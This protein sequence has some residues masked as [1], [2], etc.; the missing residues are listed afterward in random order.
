MH[1]LKNEKDRIGGEFL[2]LGKNQNKKQ[3]MLLLLFSEKKRYSKNF[4]QK[5]KTMI[6]FNFFLSKDNSFQKLY[7]NFCSKFFG[8]KFFSNATAKS[9]KIK[10]PLLTEQLGKTFLFFHDEL[11]F[12]EEFSLHYYTNKFIAIFHKK[13]EVS[14][15]KQ[16]QRRDSQKKHLG[17]RWLKQFKEDTKGY[18]RRVMR[19]YLK[20]I[21]IYVKNSMVMDIDRINSRFFIFFYFLTSIKRLSKSVSIFEKR[22]RIL[23]NLFFIFVFVRCVL[24]FFIGL[25][26]SNSSF[27]KEFSR[28]N[29]IYGFRGSRT[30]IFPKTVFLLM[31]SPFR[32]SCLHTYS[33]KL[34][35]YQKSWR[36]LLRNVLFSLQ[37]K[38]SLRNEYSHFLFFDNGHFLLKKKKKI[39]LFKNNAAMKVIFRRRMQSLLN[40]KKLRSILLNKFIKGY[41]R[42]Q[43]VSC[44]S[45][46]KFLVKK[47]RFKPN[48]TSFSDF[49]AVL[50]SRIKKNCFGKVQIFKFGA[51]LLRRNSNISKFFFNFFRR[52]ISLFYFIINFF[53]FFAHY[54]VEQKR[55][56]FD[57]EDFFIFREFFFFTKRVLFELFSFFHTS[58]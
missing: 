44:K 10:L 9:F 28:I 54:Y 43:R 29:L 40:S 19:K 13:R 46:S 37:R 21:Q 8:E 26:T 30:L 38:R 50:R 14:I 56:L 36:S 49:F 58:K 18:K 41:S 55:L 51:F 52:K 22:K 35:T 24:T 2:L 25:S 20:L 31:Y 45:F 27:R 6:L 33:R 34:F 39:F 4:L 1:K 53:D 48:L 42:Q 17:K 12:I 15:R 7:N 57:L 23:R 47:N 16:Y 5:K 11:W 3:L 32:S